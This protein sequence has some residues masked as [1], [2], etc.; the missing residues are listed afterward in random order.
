MLLE[1]TTTVDAEE[2]F[3][4]AEVAIAPVGSTEQH[5]PALPL[6][7]DFKAA[8]TVARGV[9]DRD[10]VVVL[11]TIPVGVSPHHRQFY[12]T[13][14]VS[15]ETF[16]QYLAE[17]LAS[18]TDHGIEK[19]IVVNGHGGNVTAIERVARDF[20]RDQTAFVVPW[21]W[22]EG[23]GETPFEQ[24]GDD[25]EVP[26]HAG[27]VEAAMMLYAAGHL[28]EEDR[29]EDAATGR[30]S[31]SR[32]DHPDVRGFDFA[33]WT[34]NGVSGDPRQA[35]AEAGELLYQASSDALDELVDW[36]ATLP[37]DDLT[38]RPHE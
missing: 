28:V 16:E 26:G 25:V 1:E 29:F 15:A 27:A 8:E 17:S 7:T 3:A 38:P 21:S 32:F 23:V 36:L 34:D 12:G 2:A 18:L 13:L 11:P 35:S 20:Y 14:W 5:G 33:D 22:W 10:D 24:F 30:G 4:D 37:A 6:C 19:I 31:G 9:A